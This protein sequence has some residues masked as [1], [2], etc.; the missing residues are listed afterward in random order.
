MAANAV[1]VKNDKGLNDEFLRTY[2]KA[3][4]FEAAI[5]L[6][7]FALSAAGIGPLAERFKRD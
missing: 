6:V 7:I 4:A 2:P 5:A 3:I 1:T